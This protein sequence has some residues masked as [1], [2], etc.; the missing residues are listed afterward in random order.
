MR[1][2]A[3]ETVGRSLALWQAKSMSPRSKAS[4]ISFTHRPFAPWGRSLACSGGGAPK[5]SP[6]VLM[7]TVSTF[8]PGWSFSSA[9][10][11][12]PDCAKANGEPRVPIFKSDM[13]GI[14][15]FPPHPRHRCEC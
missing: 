4:S 6:L 9:R 12:R 3:G 8:S 11:I 2:P 10:A 5:R 14:L 7:T 15:A 1:R 13:V